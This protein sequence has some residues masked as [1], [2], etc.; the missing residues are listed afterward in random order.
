MPDSVPDFSR[1]ERLA[2]RGLRVMEKQPNNEY[3]IMT[4]ALMAGTPP[5]K[6]IG[7]DWVHCQI[8]FREGEQVL[9]K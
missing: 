7:M 9:G 5:E 1:I 8:L 3:S 6:R 4:K 2:Q